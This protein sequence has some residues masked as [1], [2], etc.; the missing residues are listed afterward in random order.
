MT[1]RLTAR[2]ALLLLLPPLL[3]AGNATVGRM[4][5]GWISPLLLNALR[6]LLAFAILLPLG[7]RILR[8]D[9]PLWRRVGYFLL[10]GLLGVGSYN[11]FQYLALQTSTPINVTLIT[12]S[13]PVWTLCVG[14]LWYGERP[15]RMQIIGAVV[16]LIGVL[17]VLSHGD[18]TML[19]NVQLVPGDLFVLVAI[20]SWAFY[21]W[22]LA[23]PSDRSISSWGWAEFLQAQVAFGAFWASA[24]AF[25]EWSVGAAHVEWN[26]WI[27]AL[28]LYV[29][30]GP[31]LIA[32]RCWGIGVQRAGPAVASFFNNLTPVFAAILSSAVLGEPPRWF[33]GVAFALIVGGIAISSRR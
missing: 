10:L 22:M 1:T 21:S 31:S 5:V 15:R 18:W 7:Y 25:G 30:I 26:G 4:S 8:S 13:L 9:S 20:I 32:Y 24:A 23:R 16:S 17:L 33:H 2:T 11:A 6:W 12:S 27:V 28:L 3:W 14:A 29:A 19:A